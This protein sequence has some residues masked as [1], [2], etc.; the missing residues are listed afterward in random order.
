M[1]RLTDAVSDIRLSRRGMLIG[2]GAAAGLIVGWTF[3]PRDYV[4]EDMAAPGEQGFNAWLKIG[5]NGQ[6]AVFVPQSEMGQGSYT[7][8]AQMVAGELGA[9]WRTVGVQPAMPNALFANNLLAREWAPAL[10]PSG[11]SNALA[12]QGGQWV[13]DELATRNIFMVTAGSSTV[14]AFEQGCR[15]AGAGARAL[16]CMAAAERWGVDWESC[17]TESGFVVSGEQRLRFGELAEAAASFDLPDPVPLNSSPVNSLSGQD[18]P[19]LDLP[20]KV[21]GTASFAGD[22]RL[23]DMLFAAIR[24]APPGGGALKSFDRKAA[25]TIPG[26]VLAVRNDEWVAAVATNGWAASRALD[27]MRPVFTLGEKARADNDVQA[28]LGDV[29]SGKNGARGWTLMQQGDVEASFAKSAGTRILE[30]EYFVAPAVHAAAETRTATAH[31]TNGRLELWMASQAP[32]DARH[33]A[34]QALALSPRDVVLYPMLA[35]GSFGRNIDNRIAAEVALI[36]QEAGRPVQL[37]WSR[38]EDLGHHHFRAPALARMTGAVGRAGQ[39]VG[40]RTRIATP[41]STREQARRLV[42]GDKPADALRA[43]AGQADLLAVEGAVPPYAIANFALDHFPADVGLPTGRWRGNAHS[44]TAFFTE[45]F[46][47]ELAALSGVEPFSYRMQMMVDQTRLAR[48]LKGVADMAGWDG[49]VDKSGMGIACHSMRG[50]HIAVIVSALADDKGIRVKRISAMADCGR[51]VHPEIARQQIEG[52]LI[53]GM[54]QAV[55]ASIGFAG[56][57]LT[58]RR[59]R[60]LDLPVLADIPEVQVE[61]IRSEDAPGGIGELGVPPVAPAIANAMFS[62]TGVRLRDLPLLSR[63]L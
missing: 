32:E 25:R 46:I 15:E 26:F 44:Y 24:H 63:G 6:V 4:P 2:G 29:L 40:L 36:A 18:V 42:H 19:R 55:G 20:S 57:R 11:A 3:W 59:L 5:R 8:I 58:A 7:Q 47:D 60:D 39:L 54:A 17:A 56:G 12:G 28:T 43:I 48:C 22:I 31:F 61:F 37:V 38:A 45:C 33:Q 14:R 51:I 49:G 52:G 35:G 9:D 41:P 34:A 62:A 16:L 50:S 13:I 30:A 10:L 53:F 1:S 21:D 23:P 27:A